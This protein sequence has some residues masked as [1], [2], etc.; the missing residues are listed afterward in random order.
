M[1]AIHTERTADYVGGSRRVV[2]LNDDDDDD[3]DV[4]IEHDPNNIRDRRHHPAV[5]VAVILTLCHVE[6]D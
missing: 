6:M 1:S 5:G 2:T 4:N 3:D